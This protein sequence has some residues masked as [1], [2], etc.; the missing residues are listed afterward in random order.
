M[1][2]RLEVCYIPGLDLRRV[3]VENTPYLSKMLEKY[4]WVQIKAIPTGDYLPML[5]TG[6]YPP[7]HG[8]EVSL[9]TDFNSSINS[10]LTKRFPDLLTTTFQCLIHLFAGSFDL[11]TVPTWRRRRF[12]IKRARYVS[13]VVNNLIRFNG[14]DSIFNIIGVSKSK[15][16][17]INSIDDLKGMLMKY[18]TGENKL[19]IIEIYFIDLL[20]HWY[21]DDIDKILKNYSSIDNLLER[22]HTKLKRDN[23]SLMLL[24]DHGQEPVKGSVNIK[25][26]LNDLGLNK[27]EYTYYLEPAKARFWFHTD[28]A[29]E[30]IVNMLSSFEHGTILSYKDLHQYNLKYPDNRYGEI[31]FIT[32]LGYIIFPHDF[33]HPL[34]NLF[35]GLT[36]KQQRSRVFN[37][38]HRGYHHYLPYNESEKG[39]MMLL[40]QNYKAIKKEA[41]LIDFAPTVL[42]LLEYEKPDYMKGTCLFTK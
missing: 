12:D 15:Y 11:A 29:R 16:I 6:V 36:D 28:R 42:T 21:L 13:K 35:L 2:K 14:I 20:Q 3:D 25:G 32:D 5:L 1:I 37:P 39:F 27:D 10:V 7:E 33:Y 40:D 4:P 19:E 23:I 24:S 30:R 38:K 26:K 31:F 34:A 22:L 18:V 9:R 17:G 8:M 41:E